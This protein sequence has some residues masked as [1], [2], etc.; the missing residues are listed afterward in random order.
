MAKKDEGIIRWE[1]PPAQVKQTA[2]HKA[3]ET[4]KA[5]PKK[6]ALI[7]EGI[8]NGSITAGNIRNGK[9]K[10]FE[11]KGAFEATSRAAGEKNGKPV[12]NIHAR[13]MGK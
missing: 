10:A 4:L 8:P 2:N 6:W 1:E 12:F 3:A 9:I 5:N 7:K 11:P 13:Y